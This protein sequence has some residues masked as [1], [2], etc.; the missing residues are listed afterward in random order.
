MLY[1]KIL[2]IGM[3]SFSL[4]ACMDSSQNSATEALSKIS[5]TTITL[6]KINDIIVPPDPGAQV[7][8]TIE[9]V[10]VDHN[11]IR[12]EVDRWIATKYS[13]KPN[14]IHALQM[15]ARVSQKIIARN[16]KTKKIALIMMNENA[17]TTACV[18]KKL[19]KEGVN[20]SEYFYDNYLWT[21]NN[22]ARLDRFKFVSALAGPIYRDGTDPIIICPY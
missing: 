3:L 5:A 20:A 19:E 17:D 11:G 4:A 13:D 6:E 18:N 14:A 2:L 8:V 9:G 15:V 16:P 10:D 12:D 7:N 22:N 21:Y 1:K